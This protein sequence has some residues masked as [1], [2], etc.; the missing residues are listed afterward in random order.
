[1]SGPA[2]DEAAF[3]ELQESAGAPV[4]GGRGVTVGQGAPR[5]RKQRQSTE[6]EGGVRGT[7]T[8]PGGDR[9][10]GRPSDDHDAAFEPG[11]ECDCDQGE[12]QPRRIQRRD[13]VATL[14]EEPQRHA[15]D[16]EHGRGSASL[17]VRTR[18]V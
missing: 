4:G 13:G 17:R 10:L 18:A 7:N 9:T 5:Q 1:M 8:E 14:E 16:G 12:R 15:D 11:R 3:A 2:I 6:A